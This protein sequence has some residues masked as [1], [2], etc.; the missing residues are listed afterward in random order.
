MSDRDA[1][2]ERFRSDE[3]FLLTTH[4]NPDG[5]ALGSLVGMNCVLQALGKDTVMFMRESEFPLPYEYRYLLADDAAIHFEPSDLDER[6]VVFLDCGQFERMDV[7]FLKK[8]SLTLINIDHHHDNTCFGTLNMVVGE[9]SCTA[10]LVYSL[11]LELGVELTPGMAEALYIGLVT[12]TGRFMYQS[13]GPDAHRMAADLIE[14]GKVKVH[15]VYVRLFEDQPFG[16]VQL[17]A[18]GLSRI[19]RFDG[20][21]L[22]ITN[23]TKEDFDETSSEETFTEG[24]VD[25]VRSV[26]GTAVGAL[27]RGLTG[28]GKEHLSKI[29]LR[30]SDDR[31]DVSAIARE[32]GGGGHR[33]AAGAT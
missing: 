29:S 22:T 26:S 14:R 3:K 4:E 10:E 23:L 7:D 9:A 12:D 24:I 20:G 2:V 8:D 31:V 19:Q 16:K 27:M 28:D 6:T 5:D 33:Q 13:T 32:F 15:D 30:A 11:M 18:R 17:M 25:V 1:I 21:L